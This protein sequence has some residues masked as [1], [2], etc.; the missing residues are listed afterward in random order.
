VESTETIRGTP[1]IALLIVGALAFGWSYGFLEETQGFGVAAW[2]VFMSAV[3]IGGAVG[4]AYRNRSSG[5]FRHAL[6]AIP[7]LVAAL[8]GLALG[9][10]VAYAVEIDDRNL[11]NYSVN[12]AWQTNLLVT[13]ALATLFGSLLG[14][15]AAFLS[16]ML[17]RS[18][19]RTAA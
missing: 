19:D 7:V 15:L 1:S 3:V 5:S 10:F 4:V 8:A 13:L 14:I 12:M 16:H 9:D 11:D 2:W 18:M 6:K 17:R